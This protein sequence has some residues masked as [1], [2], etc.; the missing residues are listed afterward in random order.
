MT[1]PTPKSFSKSSFSVIEDAAKRLNLTSDAAISEALG[2]SSHGSTLAPW[3]KSGQCPRVAALAAEALVR[4][5]TQNYSPPSGQTSV[6]VLVVDESKFAGLEPV[7]RAM[8]ITY[9][10][11]L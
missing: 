7:L 11:V 1:T 9:Q 2:Y 3:R 10:K 4:R 6:V 8:Q 5:Q